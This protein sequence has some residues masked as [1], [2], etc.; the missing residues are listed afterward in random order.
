MLINCVPLIQLKLTEF[1][2]F[3]GRIVKQNVFF[4][5]YDKQFLLTIVYFIIYHLTI[6]LQ[7]IEYN[8]FHQKRGGIL[9]C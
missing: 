9:Q 2:N 1:K 5:N 7:S 8:E 6:L 4:K 3:K